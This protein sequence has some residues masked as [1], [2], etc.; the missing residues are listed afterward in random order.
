M[1]SP[2]HYPTGHK[3]PVSASWTCLVSNIYVPTASNKSVSMSPT[4]ISSSF[5][6]TTSLKGTSE[7]TKAKA[8]SCPTSASQTTSRFWTYSSRYTNFRCIEFNTSF[9]CKLSVISHFVCLSQNLKCTKCPGSKFVISEK[10]GM[11]LK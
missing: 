1:N 3:K 5:S 2:H 7:N 11:R 4:R 6:M 9:P 10:Q 8:F